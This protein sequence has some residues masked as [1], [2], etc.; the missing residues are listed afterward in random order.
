YQPILPQE[1]NY[2]WSEQL[3]LYLGVLDSKLRYFTS[4]KELVPT[5]PEVALQER[6]AKEQE[7]L[8]KEQERLAKEQERLAKDQAQH[9]AERLAQKLRELG[10]NPDEV[11]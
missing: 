9:R 10:I 1:N 2:L 11:V 6:L 7:K 5:L 3:G 8:A 4:D